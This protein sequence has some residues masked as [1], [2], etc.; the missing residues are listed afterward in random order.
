ML[1]ALLSS[2]RALWIRWHAGGWDVLILIAGGLTLGYSLRVTG[3]DQKLAAGVPTGAGSFATLAVL[4]FA[5]LTLGTFFSNTAI[6]SMLMPVAVVVAGASNQL[7]LTR[8]S[9]WLLLL[10]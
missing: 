6:A 9:W 8:C 7:D 10:P 5:T 2:A 1:P 4:G 3:M